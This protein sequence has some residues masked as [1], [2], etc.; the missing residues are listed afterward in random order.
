MK[1]VI[2]FALKKSGKGN[3]EFWTQRKNKT[4]AQTRQLAETTITWKLFKFSYS[5]ESLKL[6]VTI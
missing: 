4:Q 2:V 3:L 6:S 1:T 5:A